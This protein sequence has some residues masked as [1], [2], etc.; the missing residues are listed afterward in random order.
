M[1]LRLAV[2]SQ[3]LY[4][5][6]TGFFFLCCWLLVHNVFRSLKER[7]L[8]VLFFVSYIAAQILMMIIHDNVDYDRDADDD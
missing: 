4:P 2:N 5:L 8:G 1:S 3:E 7:C 6:A